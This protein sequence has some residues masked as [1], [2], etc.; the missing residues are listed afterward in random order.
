MITINRPTYKREGEYHY[1]SCIFKCGSI[2]FEA[3]YKTK[4]SIDSSA[5][6]FVVA[7]L[8]A[9]MH[10][11]EDIHVQGEVSSKLFS[12]LDAIQKEYIVFHPDLKHIKITSDSLYDT[13]SVSRY[14]TTAAFFTGG[15]DSFYTLL[16]NEKEISKLVYVHGFDVWL[17]E[18]EFR[19]LVDGHIEK[20]SMEFGK[21]LILVETNLH[22]FCDRY[23]NWTFYHTS[24][25][26]SVALLLS[27]NFSKIYIASAYDHPSF[28]GWGISEIDRMWSTEKMDIVP[29]GFEA[30]RINK[31]LKISHNT[32]CQDHLKVCID[33]TSGKYNCSKC[34]KCVRTIISLYITGIIEKFKTFDTHNIEELVSN[35]KI[36]NTNALLFARE[37]YNMLPEGAIKSS[38]KASIDNYKSK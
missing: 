25:L 22:E 27:N 30:N 13:H 3:W 12:S 9:A 15:A 36:L 18:T 10:H 32:T 16:K 11:G 19:K 26:A 21:E 34:E 31:I 35:F 38:L 23:K 17:Y 4:S 2:E 8:V 6:V 29:D 20:A 37:N 5:D 28:R 7:F 33:R 24:A 14:K 1:L